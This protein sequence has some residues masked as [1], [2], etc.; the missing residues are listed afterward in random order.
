[1]NEIHLHSAETSISKMFDMTP[2]VI[3][4]NDTTNSKFTEIYSVYRI[5]R[6]PLIL[7]S[8]GPENEPGIEWSKAAVIPNSF[9]I[10]QALFYFGFV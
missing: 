10:S 4:G 1:M 7:G 2:H 3:H 9:C 8:Q 5:S 6:Q